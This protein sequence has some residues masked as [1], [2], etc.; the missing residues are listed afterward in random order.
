M[1]HFKNT[2]SDR[3][4]SDILALFGLKTF[5]TGALEEEE[6]EEDSA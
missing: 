5:S 2:S 4:V 6:E 1:S 3:S